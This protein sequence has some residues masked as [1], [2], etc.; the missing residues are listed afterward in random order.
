MQKRNAAPRRVRV[1]RNIY[2]RVSG[3]YEVGFK[4]GGGVQRWR[5]VDGGIAAAR[6]IRDTLLA[7]RARGGACRVRCATPVRGRAAAWLDGPVSDL[8]PATQAGYQNAVDQH[9]LPRYAARRLDSIIPDDLSELVRELRAIGLA[10]ST[11]VIGVTNRIYRYAAG[12]LGCSGSNPVSLMLS[13]ERPKPSKDVRRRLFAPG[14]IRLGAAT[15]A[16]GGRW[17]VRVAEVGLRTATRQSALQVGGRG[18]RRRR[19][20]RHAYRS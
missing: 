18:S 11:I 15:S 4:D 16:S 17:A 13:S 3:V 6:A 9:L 14:E 12:R 10:E 8:R 5:T 2:R 7:R 19:P 1:E 20:C